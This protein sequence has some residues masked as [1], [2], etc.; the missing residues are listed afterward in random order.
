MLDHPVIRNMERYGEPH[1]R[2]I[3]CYCDECGTPIQSGDY[4]YDFHELFICRKCMRYYR[5]TAGEDE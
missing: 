3:E 5:K 1:P 2:K 4:Y